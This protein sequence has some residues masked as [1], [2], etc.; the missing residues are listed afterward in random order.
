MPRMGRISRLRGLAGALLA[1]VFVLPLA[2]PAAADPESELDEVRERQERVERRLEQADARGDKLSSQIR[3]ID[4]ERAAVESDVEAL[5]AEIA[6]FDA[7]IVAT[8]EELTAL[9]QELAILAEDLK[10][11]ARRLEASHDVY[12]GQAVE[13][14]KA[15]PSAAIDGLLSSDSFSDLVDRLEYYESALDAEQELV[16]EIQLLQDE[17]E[18]TQ[19]QVEHKKVQIAAKKLRLESDRMRVAAMREERAAVLAEKEALITAK[20]QLLAGVEAQEDQLS[21]VQ[22]QLEADSERIEAIIA[23]QAAAAAAAAAESAADNPEV[24]TSTPP[25]PDGDGAVD[26]GGQLLWPANGPMTSPYGYRIHPIFG[27]SRMHTGVDIGASYG[28]PVWAAEDGVV[29]YVG[30]MSGYGNV[31]VVDHGGNL[32]TTYNH[33]SGFYVSQGQTVSRGDTIAAVGCTGYC[34][35]PH[36]HFEVRIN[37]SPVDPMP[38]F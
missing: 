18:I 14:Y 1:L 30:T 10:V 2:I 15:G 24:S 25:A 27:Y 8:E 16:E 20:S 35:G 33:L 37:G 38:Y 9:Q 7:R 13:A 3:G 4:E 22:E 28:A 32:A 23:A 17:T 26:A 19:R 36:L 29:A 21:R 34:T 5:D 11:I 31:V 6:E 12:A